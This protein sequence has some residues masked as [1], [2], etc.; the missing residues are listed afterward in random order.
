[1]VRTVA[2]GALAALEVSDEVHFLR[3]QREA[4]GGTYAA[5]DPGVIESTR[6]GG[7]TAVATGGKVCGDE[8]LRA[9]G[10]N[11][12]A[13]RAKNAHQF[14]VAPSRIQ[15][16][17]YQEVGRLVCGITR[18]INKVK[19]AATPTGRGDEEVVVGDAASKRC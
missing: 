4:G 10:I 16:G 5:A 9:A 12:V 1:M 2:N 13:E 11:A 19:K 18:G 6:S 17:L 8:R 15:R 7:K 3:Y 14:V